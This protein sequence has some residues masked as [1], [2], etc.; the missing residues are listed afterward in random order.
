M[1]TPVRRRGVAALLCAVAALSATGCSSERSA[2]GAAAS[3][4]VEVRLGPAETVAVPG[5][6]VGA[7]GGG[8]SL[9]AILQLL[10]QASEDASV[11]GV[12][13]RLDDAV[14][15][16]AEGQ[17]VAEQVRRLRQKG[18]AVV[19]YAE[20]YTNEQYSLAALADEVLCAPT[21]DVDLIGTG[22]AMFFYKDLLDSVGIRADLEQIGA[23]KSAAEPFTRRDMSAETRNM[24]NRLLDDLYS[25]MVTEIATGRDMPEAEVRRLV[26][27][28]PY[29]AAEALAA[30]LLD[31]LIY[32]D[33]LDAYVDELV[34]R[35][36]ELE[37]TEARPRDRYEGVA[38]L[39]RLWRDANAGRRRHRSRREKIALVHVEGVIVQGNVVDPWGARGFCSS[40]VVREALDDAASDPTVKAIVLRVDSPGGGALASD[41]IWRAVRRA[42]EAKPVVG[43][44]GSVAASGGYYAAMAADHILAEHATLTGSIGVFGGKFDL[45]GLYRKLGIRKQ[46]L[47]RGEHAMLYDEA[48]GFTPS[49]R[50]RLRAHMESTYREFVA[51]AAESRAMSV[52]DIEAVAA[53]QVWTGREALAQ[54]L[55]DEIGGLKRAFEVAKT[56]AGYSADLRL[57]LL[58]LPEEPSLLDVLFRER[59]SR[60]LSPADALVRRL[61]FLTRLSQERIFAL[62][63]YLLTPP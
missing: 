29:T 54:G 48:S 16:G 19:A 50:A 32:E 11:A 46:A 12:L 53:G 38:G 37:R 39:L 24:Y 60:L 30:D 15:S 8:P 21:G 57:E 20:A 14:L 22:F 47:K 17:E 1:T 7:A 34:G 63:P 10:D 4:F 31:A 35:D 40:G 25:Q 5:P 61:P 6:L 55:V 28:G 23:Y 56:K 51:K 43:S 2:K 9:L 42:R 49:E 36:V 62:E 45:G 18:K 33:E 52:E 27:G 3:R 13:L 26:D 58:E 41:I 59:Q 44:M